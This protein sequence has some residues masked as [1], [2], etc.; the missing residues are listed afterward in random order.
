MTTVNYRYAVQSDKQAI[1]DLLKINTPAIPDGLRADLFDWQ[2]VTANPLAKERAHFLVA[3]VDC[4]VAGVN[5]MMPVDVRVSGQSSRLIWSCDTLV[6]DQFRG[7]GI[8]KELLSRVSHEEPLVLGY[9]ISD[10][11]DPILAKLGWHHFSEVSTL[12]FYA[13][14]TGIRG[15]AKNVMSMLRSAPSSLKFSAPDVSVSDFAERFGEAHDALWHRVEADYPYAVVRDSGYLNW[16]YRDHPYLVYDVLEAQRNK[17]LAA[18]LI[19]RH[20]P[21]ESVI[22]DFVGPANDHELMR[23]LVREAKDRLM[24]R[25]VARI[26][27]ETSLSCLKQS[28]REAGFIDYPGPSRF[29]FFVGDTI[30]IP[31]SDMNWF[32]MTGDSDNESSQVGKIFERAAA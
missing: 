27:C 12:F 17:N 15:K 4:V 5:G 20:D 7:M 16:R 26:R 9:G 10:M 31:N 2:F 3:E 32:V 23:Q 30:S 29:R 11:S 22:A 18:L 28:L 6:S 1:L 19:I 21:Y 25:G 24:A 8:G 14:E 13:N